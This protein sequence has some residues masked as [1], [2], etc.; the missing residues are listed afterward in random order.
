MEPNRNKKKGA[1]CPPPPCE[2]CGAVVGLENPGCKE[3]QRRMRAR[4]H[5]RKYY[6]AK[7]RSKKLE[8][9]PVRKYN[10]LT[11]QI[12]IGEVKDVRLG[13]GYTEPGTV[14]SGLDGF[15]QLRAQRIA[16]KN[17]GGVGGTGR[18]SRARKVEDVMRREKQGKRGEKEEG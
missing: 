8:G 5:S 17:G 14:D 3:C 11:P 18:G 10:M 12:G 7:H 2:E 1:Y 15:L 13:D 16:R 4:A 9:T 6:R